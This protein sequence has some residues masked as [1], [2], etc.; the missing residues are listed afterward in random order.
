MKDF[1]GTKVAL[2]NNN[3]VLVI[4]R[5]DKPGIDFPGMWDLP[6]GAR[7]DGELPIEVAVREVREEVGLDLKSSRPVWQKIYPAVADPN[8]TAY[9]LVFN[10]SDKQLKKA[11]LGDEGRDWKMVRFEDFLSNK[12]AVPGM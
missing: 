1:S 9:F 3:R 2:I 12:N 7:E 10:I 6:G 8:K 11:K 5:D 4:L